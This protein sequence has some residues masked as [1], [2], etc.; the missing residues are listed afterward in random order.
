VCREFKN[1]THTPD[2]LAGGSRRK[3]ALVLNITKTRLIN[4]RPAKIDVGDTIVKTGVQSD[5]WNNKSI[6]QI[7]FTEINRIDRLRNQDIGRGIDTIRFIM[8]KLDWNTD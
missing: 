3:K 6:N 8:P 2:D 1:W 5:I 7:E 4:T